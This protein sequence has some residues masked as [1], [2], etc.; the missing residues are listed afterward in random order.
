VSLAGVAAADGPRIT[1]ERLEC[2]RPSPPVPTHRIELN[3]NSV[4]STP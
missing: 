2:F 3:I 1:L 4:D